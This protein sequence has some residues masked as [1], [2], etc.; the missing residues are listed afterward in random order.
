MQMPAEFCVD[1]YCKE[2]TRPGGSFIFF[3]FF[4]RSKTSKGGIYTENEIFP[5]HE[6]DYVTYVVNSIKLSS[7]QWDAAWP[8][9]LDQLE[10]SLS[11]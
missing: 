1:P 6:D 9:R 4:F 7:S 5:R 8:I 10:P 2:L 11:A 3:F